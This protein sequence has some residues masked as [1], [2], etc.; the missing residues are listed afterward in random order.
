MLVDL[1]W[2]TLLYLIVID[3]FADITDHCFLLL[4]KTAIPMRIVP[5]GC[6]V[7][8]DLVHSTIVPLVVPEGIPWASVLMRVPIIGRPEFRAVTSIR[9]PRWS[10]LIRCNTLEM[11]VLGT[12][13]F[14]SVFVKVRWIHCCYAVGILREYKYLTID[15]T[16]PFHIQ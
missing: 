2:R 10:I 1:Y 15:H 4:L 7:M 8:S 9:N 3:Y 6:T 12:R 16:C 13:R 14:P 5:T 11:M